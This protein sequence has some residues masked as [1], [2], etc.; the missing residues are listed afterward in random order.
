MMKNQ[1]H[2]RLTEPPRLLT[3]VEVAECAGVTKPTVYRQ[4]QSGRL[5][6]TRIGGRTLVHPNDYEA[7][8]DLCRGL[9]EGAGDAA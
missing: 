1:G 3:I 4:I 9:E 2:R 8:I 7:W 6:V 5:R